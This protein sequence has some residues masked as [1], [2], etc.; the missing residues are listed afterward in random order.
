MQLRRFENVQQFWQAT[1][2]YLLQY[3]AEHNAMLGILQTALRFPEH[4]PEPLYLALVE[5][6]GRILAMAIRTPPQ[7]LMLSKVQDS[8]ALNL[9]TQDLQHQQLSGVNGL[10][11]EAAAFA[12]MWQKL[13]GQSYRRE[14]ESRIYQITQV[15]SVARARGH[16]RLATEVDRMLL[17]QW[18]TEFDATLGEMNVEDTKRRV[19]V[20]LQ[21]QSIYL[22]EDGD[23]VSMVG[24]RQIS[25]TAARIAP[26]YT[27]P[28]Y[29]RKGYATAGVAALSQRF[30]NQGC[31]CFLFADLANPV[32]NSIYQQIGYYPVY[33]WHE[34]S[35]I[36]TGQSSL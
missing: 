36:S 8:N 29:R 27:P 17:L 4:Y 12:Q 6:N 30:L 16:L 34:Y 20:Q 31:T 32:S 10:L 9:I 23:P 1:Q 18:F 35:F 2:N 7:Y 24:G 19:H 33:D 15:E 28:E 14:I 3:E 22:W 26:V 11:A 13:T 25:A 21:R 5:A